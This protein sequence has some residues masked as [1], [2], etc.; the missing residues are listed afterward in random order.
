MQASPYVKRQVSTTVRHDEELAALEH[1]A[2]AQLQARKMLAED[3][4][5]D[6]IELTHLAVS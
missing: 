3:A 1:F 5:S 4:K 2:A 6:K